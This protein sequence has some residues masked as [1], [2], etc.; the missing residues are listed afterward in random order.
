MPLS[1]PPSV[2]SLTAST[3]SV[4]V[5]SIAVA[6]RSSASFSRL[7]TLSTTKIF[8]APR[9]FADSAAIRPTGP[10]PKMTTVSPGLTSA[11]SVAW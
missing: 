5:K 3:G 9:I 4:A 7:C 8:E 1:A 10:A 11:S 2:C 6:P